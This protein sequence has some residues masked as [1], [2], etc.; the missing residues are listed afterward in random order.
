MHMSCKYKSS[1]SFIH[2]WNAEACLQPHLSPTLNMPTY[3]FCPCSASYKLYFSPFLESSGF[4]RTNIIMISAVAMFAIVWN[5]RQ[6]SDMNPEL[7]YSAVVP[8]LESLDPIRG[9]TKYTGGPRGFDC[10]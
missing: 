5:W 2:S 9:L 1:F 8:N 3:A 4:L 10:S 6:D 7:P